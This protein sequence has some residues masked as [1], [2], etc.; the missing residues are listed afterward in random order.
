MTLRT[1]PG[2]S[3]TKASGSSHSW[4]LLI[5]LSAHVSNMLLCFFAAFICGGKSDKKLVFKTKLNHSSKLHKFN[6]AL[7]FPRL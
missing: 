6:S 4:L 7:F 2:A 5:T 1:T 3:K